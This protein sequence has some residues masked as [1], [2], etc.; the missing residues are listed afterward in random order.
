[1]VEV[2]GSALLLVAGLVSVRKVAVL[3]VGGAWVIL[4]SWCGVR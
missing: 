4:D 2:D 3:E 1:M